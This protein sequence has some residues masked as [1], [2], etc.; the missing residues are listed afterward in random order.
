MEVVMFNCP[1]VGIGASS[2]SVVSD[3]A[4]VGVTNEVTQSCDHLVQVCL[5][6]N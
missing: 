6:I 2:V 4:V 5:I 1:S 3:G